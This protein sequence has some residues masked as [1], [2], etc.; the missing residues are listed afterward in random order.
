MKKLVS[1]LLVLFMLLSSCVAFAEATTEPVEVAPF[2]FRG[3]LTWGMSMDEVVA[4]EGVQP[5]E[6]EE[7][8]YHITKYVFED[9]PFSNLSCTITYW[10]VDDGLQQ[11]QVLLE[12]PWDFF[13]L[14]T[15]AIVDSLTPSLEAVYGPATKDLEKA[16]EQ[17]I[18]AYK[19]ITSGKKPEGF[20]VPSFE[21]VGKTVYSLWVPAEDSAIALVGYNETLY[22]HYLNTSIDW[23]VAINEPA[24]EV[25]PIDTTGL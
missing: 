25:I 23:D 22:L 21:T 16:D 8:S 2:T 3:G 13:D 20:Y 11:S 15:P 9:R 10:F 1:V 19:A 24:P 7:Y 5:V 17:L 6:I 12:S 4:I 18:A 14:A